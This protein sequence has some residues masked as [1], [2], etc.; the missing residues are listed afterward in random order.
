M[1]THI[2]DL[3]LFKI[4]KTRPQ[5]VSLMHNF[6]VFSICL[7]HLLL[8]S[9]FSL[10]HK[11][12]FFSSDKRTEKSFFLLVL[13]RDVRYTDVNLVEISQC[14]LISCEIF[15]KKRKK[16][17]DIFQFSSPS[18]IFPSL[19]FKERKKTTN[20]NKPSIPFYFFFFFLKLL[21]FSLIMYMCIFKEKNQHQQTSYCIV[22]F[23]KKIKKK[24]MVKAIRASN[25][26][27]K[28]YD[29]QQLYF[30][31]SSLCRPFV[32]IVQYIEL[33][34]IQFEDLAGQK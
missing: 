26:L 13:G 18:T 21:G 5:L 12:P 20:T 16:E 1:A 33:I 28:F 7:R 32:Y 19:S 9:R 14:T 2:F 25:D 31:I 11:L 15:Q 10:S 8:F 29:L 3:I 24:V 17:R 4:Y 27:Y 6:Q 30:R 34:Y 23:I 22:N